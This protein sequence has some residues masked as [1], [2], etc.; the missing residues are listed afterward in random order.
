MWVYKVTMISRYPNL[1]RLMII[2]FGC[3]FH[4]YCSFKSINNVRKIKVIDSPLR[5][6][7]KDITIEHKLVNVDF[8]PKT[9]IDEMNMGNVIYLY[10]VTA[11]EISDLEDSQLPVSKSFINKLK[12][13]KHN[14]SREKFLHV[15]DVGID[16]V[17]NVAVGRIPKLSYEK[18]ELGRKVCHNYLFTISIIN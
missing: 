12:S 7:I 6:T 2:F 18:L 1:I 9:S 14:L 17:C 5:I 13:A 8:S 4:R 15:F 16:S 10:D 11:R 3:V